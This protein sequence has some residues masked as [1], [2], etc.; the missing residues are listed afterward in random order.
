MDPKD[1]LSRLIPS[2]RRPQSNTAPPSPPARPSAGGFVGMPM[3]EWSAWGMLALLGMA[4]GFCNGLLGAA[5]GVLLVLLLPRLT[6]P[7]PLAVEAEGIRSRR[8][9]GEGLSRRDLL[10]TSMTVMLPV[11]AVSGVIY[12]LGG[13]RPA[14]ETAILLVLPSVVGGLLGARLL[15]KLPEDVLRRLF[16]L[17]LVI[18]GVRMLF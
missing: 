7:S 4:A 13:I 5:G 10:A 12:W 6:L 14:G 9:F 15:G 1:F 11:S 17:L 2:P 3:R 8:P 18:S 16:A